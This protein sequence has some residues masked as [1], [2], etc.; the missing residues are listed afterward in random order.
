MNQDLF[1]TCR[2]C[3]VGF[4]PAKSLAELKLSYCGI[5]CQIAAEGFTI[6]SFLNMERKPKV[7][8]VVPVAVPDAGPVVVTT[9]ADGDDRELV[10]A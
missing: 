6:E 7:T 3:G 4:H 9:G 8:A 1:R 2:R 10:P 5:L